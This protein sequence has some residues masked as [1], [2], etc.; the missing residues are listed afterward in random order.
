[1]DYSNSTTEN[2]TD[3]TDTFMSFLPYWAV[4][5]RYVMFWLIIII[6]IIGNCM[7]IIA[8][9]FSQKLQTST[10]VFV[11]SLAVTDLLTCLVLALGFVAVVS[12]SP[13]STRLN[14]ICQFVAFVTYSA[15]GSSLYTL[16]TIGINRLLLF[17][18]PNLCR[19]I[20]TSWKLG[21][22][23]VIPWIIPSGTFLIVLLNKVGAVG[24]DPV[25]KECGKVNTHERAAHLDLLIFAV[26]LP[27]PSVA[28]TVSYTWIYIYVKKHFKTQKQ[29]LIHLGVT[30]P[31]G[32]GSSS[33][34]SRA[35]ES[36]AGEAEITL[37][38]PRIKEINMQQVQ[39]TKNLF[40]VVCAFFICFVPVS[41]IILLGKKSLIINDI[42]WYLELLGYT[43]SAI[44]FFI[45]ASRHPDFKVV[46]GHMMRCS[47]SKIPQPSRLLNSI[48]SKNN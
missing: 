13:T 26:G 40:L 36:T 17:T 21:I 11:T 43:N 32:A 5:L 3:S 12:L 24:F 10:N 9:A 31:V 1:M 27:I 48:L 42:A 2:I 47:Y 25:D 45:Y 28:I 7:I 4:V 39:I 14:N 38:N 41:I 29:Q 30:S 16:G 46:L 22:F 6:G 20:F 34:L 44:N 23:V 15:I 37:T 8:I 33:L 35:K 19:R 18:K